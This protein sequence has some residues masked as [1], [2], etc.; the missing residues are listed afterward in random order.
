MQPRPWY[1]AP[2]VFFVPVF[3]T[4][5]LLAEISAELLGDIDK[6]LLKRA[7]D[8]LADATIQDLLREDLDSPTA[9]RAAIRQQ[10]V[11]LCI[12]LR[13]N[14]IVIDRLM[15]VSNSFINKDL[16]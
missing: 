3:L 11:Q 8:V 1:V 12:R 7:R 4:Y 14:L 5:F 15:A 9:F 2:F 13:V 6:D 16:K 10:V